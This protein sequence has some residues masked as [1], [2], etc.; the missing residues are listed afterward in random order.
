MT[1]HDESH[2]PTLTPAVHQHTLKDIHHLP[3]PLLQMLA[4]ALVTLSQTP[5][6]VCHGYH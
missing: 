6:Y 4:E 2:D 3:V 1:S 5:V